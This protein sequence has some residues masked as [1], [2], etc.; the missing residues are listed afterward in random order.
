M[1]D[2]DFTINTITHY[3]NFRVARCTKK[4]K[5]SMAIE[6]SIRVWTYFHCKNLLCEAQKFSKELISEICYY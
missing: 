4:K 5:L 1:S 6:T 3:K 2:S